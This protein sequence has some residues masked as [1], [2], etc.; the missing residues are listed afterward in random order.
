MGRVCTASMVVL[1][2][3][4]TLRAT[5][6]CRALLRMATEVGGGGRRL[7]EVRSFFVGDG[8]GAQDAEGASCG[9][10]EVEIAAGGQGRFVPLVLSSV[11][12]VVAVAVAVVK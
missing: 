9:A 8:G 12:V 4:L 1:G 10:G 7:G 3:G 6:A 2:F 11:A 5:L